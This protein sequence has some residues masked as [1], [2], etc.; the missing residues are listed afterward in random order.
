MTKDTHPVC[1]A[2]EAHYSFNPVTSAHGTTPSSF[3]G[4]QSLYKLRSKDTV[5]NC[6]ETNEF[7]WNMPT[8]GLRESV[9][10]SALE[11]WNDEFE[12]GGIAKAPSTLVRPPRVRDSPVALECRVHSIH[13]VAN[14]QHGE[15]MFGP[16][17]VGNSDI[18]IG[19]V[20]GVHIKGEYITGEGVSSTFLLLIPF[21]FTSQS[22]PVWFA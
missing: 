11:T 13:R 10:S 12:E 18:V 22:H 6:I 16:H 17:L 20:L 8:Y 2:K 14:Q 19:R 5:L 7:V 4:H 9:V 3:V 1:F 15:Q 21:L